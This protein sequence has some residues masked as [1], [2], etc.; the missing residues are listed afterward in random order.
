MTFYLM[1]IMTINLDCF[2]KSLEQWYF[3][4]YWIR[5]I[6]S[7]YTLAKCCIHDIFAVLLL[8]QFVFYKNMNTN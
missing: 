2:I 3:G 1:A 7:L 8:I 5:K 4:W 6:W